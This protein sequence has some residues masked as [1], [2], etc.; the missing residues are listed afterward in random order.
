LSAPCS[1]RQSFDA[2]GNETGIYAYGGQ[3][4]NRALELIG[5]ELGMFA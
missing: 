3:V 4:A 2:K 5:K 1:T